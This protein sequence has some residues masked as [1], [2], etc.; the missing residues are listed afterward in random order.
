[1]DHFKVSA[2]TE[3][4][5]AAFLICEYILFLSL[6]AYIFEPFLSFILWGWGLLMV[7]QLESSIASDNIKIVLSQ[8]VPG[9]INRH[10][11]SMD[12]DNHQG[13]CLK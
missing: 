1:L 9:A 10:A 8:P 2:I 11:V 3:A 4:Y 6:H 12:V 5:S 13:L 7:L